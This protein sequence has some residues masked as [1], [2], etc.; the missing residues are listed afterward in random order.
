MDRWQATD[1]FSFVAWVRFDSFR[2]WSR[3]LYLRDAGDAHSVQ[4]YNHEATR[5]A[6]FLV[7]HGGMTNH[8]VT[9]PPGDDDALFFKAGREKIALCDRVM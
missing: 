8:R 1:G 5:R 6:V 9:T 2:A 4:V 7:K 3:L